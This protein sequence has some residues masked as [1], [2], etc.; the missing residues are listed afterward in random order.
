[1]KYLAPGMD[2]LLYEYLSN[3]IPLKMDI[4]NIKVNNNLNIFFIPPKILQ[5][6]FWNNSQKN[7]T[8]TQLL[9]L[10]YTMIFLPNKSSNL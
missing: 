8:I 3:I 9:M 4:T 5:V 2:F 6:L 7:V 10:Y 1:M